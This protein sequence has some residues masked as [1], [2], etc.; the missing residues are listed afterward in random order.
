MFLFPSCCNRFSLVT[1]RREVL[2]C[3]VL[4][5][6]WPLPL[7]IAVAIFPICCIPF[8][9]TT[10]DTIN[11]CLNK[12]A[13]VREET[14]QVKVHFY[15]NSDSEL[16][17]DEAGRSGTTEREALKC[18][19]WGSLLSSSHYC[20]THQMLLI[21]KSKEQPVLPLTAEIQERDRGK[22]QACGFAAKVCDGEGSHVWVKLNGPMTIGQGCSTACQLQCGDLHL[23]LLLWKTWDMK[24]QLW[25]IKRFT[26][27]DNF[28]LC[29]GQQCSLCPSCDHYKQAMAQK[30]QN[31]HQRV[32][33][34][35]LPHRPV[36]PVGRKPYICKQTEAESPG[37][38]WEQSWGFAELSPLQ[39][40]RGQIDAD[41]VGQVGLHES[42][43]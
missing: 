16:S 28:H 3:K 22:V 20:L 34:A 12:R 31:W 41:K 43:H 42:P 24:E 25:K 26:M 18:R 27:F 29:Q 32:S 14:A 8:F 30:N 38:P 37:M 40:C 7:W 10:S 4:S 15:T 35:P 21:S 23:Y 17:W 1:E 19:I 36:A 13:N 6:Y 39:L 11:A 33:E 9:I 5:K 2:L